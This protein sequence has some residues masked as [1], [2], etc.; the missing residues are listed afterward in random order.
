MR[1]EEDAELAKKELEYWSEFPKSYQ[2]RLYRL[3]RA[4]DRVTAPKDAR[5]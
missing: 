4:I 3:G 1:Y 2:S 5:E